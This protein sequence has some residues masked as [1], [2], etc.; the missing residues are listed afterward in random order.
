MSLRTASCSCGRLQAQVATEP[1]RVSKSYRSRQ[2]LMSNVV[3]TTHMLRI[4]AILLALSTTCLGSTAATSSVEVYDASRD[5]RIPLVLYEPAADACAAHCKV[6]IFG[7]GYLATPSDYSFLLEA[8][9]QVGYFV[10]ALQ[11]DLPS[12]ARMPN[13]GNVSKDRAPYWEQG[14]TSI[15]FV[16]HELSGRLTSLDWSSLT[17][18]GHSNGGDIAALYA[19]KYREGVRELITLDNR[20]VPLTS[21]ATVRVLSLRSSDQPADPG[22]LP[23]NEHTRN[24]AVCIVKMRTT[25]H[26]DMNNA[27]SPESKKSI[28]EVMTRFL[29][30]GSCAS[31][32]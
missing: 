3:I 29:I 26:D 5:R 22:V 32:A 21:A 18:V 7:T 25:R 31:D 30:D 17:L 11:H 19:S 1:L 23:A 12:D 24:R 20:R 9:A 10:V 2:P 27:G 13:T 14:A 28:T 8:L 6:V 4:L 15:Q 16:A